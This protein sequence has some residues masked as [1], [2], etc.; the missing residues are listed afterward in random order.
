M[1]ACGHSLSLSPTGKCQP[2]PVELK[3]L[4]VCLQIA[5]FLHPSVFT[6]STPLR[7]NRPAIS[8]ATPS[9]AGGALMDLT[10]GCG[11]H[12]QDPQKDRY[13]RWVA[14]PAS[15]G[16][17]VAIQVCPYRQEITRLNAVNAMFRFSPYWLR[18]A[19]MRSTVNLRTLKRRT[20]HKLGAAATA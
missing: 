9:R 19:F 3:L 15:D 5:S 12:V 16:P 11:G 4:L 7:L 2:L 8:R 13:G 20:K 1:P 10:G 17:P 14:K 18:K 6:A